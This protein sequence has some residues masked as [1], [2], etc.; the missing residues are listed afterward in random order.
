M[1]KPISKL[2]Q[3]ISEVVRL[4]TADIQ[5]ERMVIHVREAKGLKDRFVML[6]EQNFGHKAHSS[7][8]VRSRPDRSPCGP[9]N[10]LPG[11]R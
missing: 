5:A 8:L 7:S 11:C 1:T 4:I 3:R 9:C 2:R 10:G 6:S